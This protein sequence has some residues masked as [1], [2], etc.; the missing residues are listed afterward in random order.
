MTRNTDDNWTIGN[1][2]TNRYRELVDLD[3]QDYYYEVEIY[4]DGEY[5]IGQIDKDFLNRFT[6]RTWGAKNKNRK[7]FSICIVEQQ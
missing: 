4:G 7:I 1:Y 2:K 6:E 3:E 5:H